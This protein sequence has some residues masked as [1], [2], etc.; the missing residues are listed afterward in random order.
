MRQKFAPRSHFICSELNRLIRSPASAAEIDAD[1]SSVSSP[2]ATNLKAEFFHLYIDD[3]LVP[4]TA[5]KSLLDSLS[6]SLQHLDHEHRYLHL[7]LGQRGRGVISV[8]NQPPI[9]RN[10]KS[11][12]SWYWLTPCSSDIAE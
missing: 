8:A 12:S 10:S 6:M 9:F 4:D 2:N 11:M 5:R 1:L 3:E 7:L